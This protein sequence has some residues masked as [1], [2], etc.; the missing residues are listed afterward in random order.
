MKLNNILATAVAGL[1]IVSCSE[2]DYMK[3]DTSHN[4]VY[5]EDDSLSYSFSVTP[6]EVKT[7]TYNIPVKIMGTV[8]RDESRKIGYEILQYADS[9]LKND[10]IVAVK[11][12]H[13]EILNDVVMPDSIT[14]YI[15][16]Q[17]NRDELEG[18]YA[19][20]YKRY[21]LG[22]RLVKN[23]YFSPTLTKADQQLIFSFDNAV[24]KPLW[25]QGNPFWPDYGSGGE[26]DYGKWHPYKL[27]KM[28]EYFHAL[29]D[30]LPET[31]KN[32]VEVYGEN[33][34][35]INVYPSDYRTV[36]RK[37]VETPLYEFLTDPAN[38]DMILAEYPDFPFDFPNPND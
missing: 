26:G 37:Y 15:I 17:I 25:Q 2:T 10:T 6:T 3:Y 27:I 19:E 31:Y 23:E 38:K 24:E 11:G 30:I 29:K 34:E 20:G 13:Y 5:F 9:D 22:L 12:K 1:L 4:G 35:F 14:G 8:S 16:V 32:M 36:F 18:T 21:R 33:L 28:V 7:Y